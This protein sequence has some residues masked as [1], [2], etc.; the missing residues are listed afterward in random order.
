MRELKVPPAAVDDPKAVEIL[1]LWVA[2]GGEWVTVNPHFWRDRD[3]S[4]EWA[5]GLFLSDTIKHVAN[6][7]NELSGKDKQKV[8]AE[9]RASF[10]AEL[11]KPTSAVRGG[12]LQAEPAHE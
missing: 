5:W 2:Q 10:E 4:E 12:I 11:E 6:A 3:F 8:I 9:I 1:R 7:I